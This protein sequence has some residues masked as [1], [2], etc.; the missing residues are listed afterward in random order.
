M[1]LPRTSPL[2]ASRRRLRCAAASVLL[3]CAACTPPPDTP[4]D[5]PAEPQVTQL[6]DTI[7][8]PLDTARETQQTLDAA[9]ARQRQAIEDAGG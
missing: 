6:R 9:A 3:A 5:K 1:S 2:S 7:Q 8:Q 4:T